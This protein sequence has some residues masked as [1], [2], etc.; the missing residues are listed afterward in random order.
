MTGRA[1][2]LKMFMAGGLFCAAM[3]AMPHTARAQCEDPFSASAA[4]A[5]LL[6][7]Q[8]SLINLY[9]QQEVNYLDKDLKETA[10]EEVMDRLDQF[11]NTI[12]DA[13]NAYAE[14]MLPPMKDM[15]AQLSTAEVDQTRQLGSV[16]D[17]RM[18]AETIRRKDRQEVRLR[19]EIDPSA[20]TCVLD[21]MASAQSQGYRIGR[22]VARGL[23]YDAQRELSGARGTV[24]ARGTAAAAAALQED[25]AAKYCDPS[26]G[27]QGCSEPGVMAGRNNDLGGMLWGDRQ[28]IDMSSPENVA[29]MEAVARNIAGPLPPDPIPSAHIASAG[30]IQE[31]V[32]RRSH[33]ARINTIYNSLG[34]MLGQRVGGTGADTQAIRGEAGTAPEDASTNASYREIEEA[35]SRDRFTDPK[36]LFGLVNNPATLVRE[37]GAVN[38]VRMAQVSEL[39]KRLE[40]LVW[41]E[42][43]VLG[44]MLDE[45][46][47]K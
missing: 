39:Y 9:T 23:S 30:G 26:V 45:E 11:R 33:R 6:S 8:T 21:T 17:A 25:F 22:A 15:S 2:R 34:Q 16:D 43:A 36:Y 5:A 37:L 3:L 41:L 18:Q 19:R 10:T 31:G 44:T 7:T 24:S 38:A 47:Q 12:L 46:A 13:L 35:I 20:T 27:D 42:G 4:T 32:R 1:V 14:R 40:E 28:T 29:A